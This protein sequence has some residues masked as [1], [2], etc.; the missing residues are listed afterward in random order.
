MF[1]IDY[2]YLRPK[3][4]QWLRRMYATPFPKK[5]SLA[6]WQGKNAT[7]LP[8]REVV[9]EGLLFGLGG[10]ADEN[11][12]YVELSGFPERIGKGYAFENPVYKDEKVVYCGYLV[13]HWGHFLI[14]GVTRL[15]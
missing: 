5:Q 11:G 12:Q 13:N 6:V 10:V 1:Q 8:L 15:W 2:S 7:I 3:K 9:N 14:E 4:A